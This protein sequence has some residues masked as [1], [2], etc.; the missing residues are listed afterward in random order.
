M[1]KKYIKPK[2]KTHGDI[3]TITK[4]GPEGGSDGEGASP[5]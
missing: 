2:L 4:Y 5:S 1:K 3:K